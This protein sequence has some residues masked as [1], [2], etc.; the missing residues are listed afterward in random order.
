MEGTPGA[1][2]GWCRAVASVGGPFGHDA[3]EHEGIL[4]RGFALNIDNNKSQTTRKDF[5]TK[6]HVPATPSEKKKF[7]PGGNQLT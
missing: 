4:P 3:S 7:L 2:P 1:Q 6:P 5:L